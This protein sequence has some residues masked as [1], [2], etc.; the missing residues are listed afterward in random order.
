MLLGLCFV[1]SF[2]ILIKLHAS[3]LLSLHQES[4]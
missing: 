2:F 1:L 4:S 3:K